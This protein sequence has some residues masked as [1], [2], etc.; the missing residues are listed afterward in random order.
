MADFTASFAV[1]LQ[2]RISGTARDA[3]QSLR[4]L[5]DKIDADTKSLREMRRAMRRLKGGTT[6]STQAFA[7]LRDEIAAKQATI[8]NA[9]SA[10]IEMGGTFG[11]VAKEATKPSAA[12]DA[13]ETSVSGAA[14]SSPLIAKLS[15]TF[16]ELSGSSVGAAASV[17]AFASKVGVTLVSLLKNPVVIALALA[18]AI[19]KVATAAVSAV[20]ALGKYSVAQASAYRADRLRL[21]GLNSLD[22]MRRRRTASVDDLT[23][24]ILGARDATGA[25]QESLTGYAR[26]LARAGLEGDALRQAVE[27]AGMAATV[28]GE[29][30]ARRFIGL[31]R[32]ARLSGRSVQD[33]TARYRDELG[34]AA[35][36][37]MLDPSRQ[38]TRFKEN[39]GQ[40]F[41]GLK[42]DGFLEAL[43]EIG[44]L[45]SQNSASGRALKSVMESI[46]QPLI[47]FAKRALQRAKPAFQT[48]ILN[49]LRMRLGGV[50]L[51]NTY[52]RVRNSLQ[53]FAYKVQDFFSFDGD[54]I[55]DGLI[56]GLENGVQRAMEAAGE[57]AVA[58]GD[59]FKQAL[60]IA[61]PSRVFAG[62]GGDIS[63]GIV[64]GM[65]SGVV[66]AEARRLAFSASSAFETA[67][68]PSLE[69]SAARVD[70][71]A[72]P[73]NRSQT[74]VSIGD[75]YI[76]AG[77]TSD[78]R[79]LADS[80]REQ[81]A[82]AL[83]GVSIEMGAA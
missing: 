78:P 3:A 6:T 42:L 50:R 32:A 20:V 68:M 61:S 14:G 76:Q 67:P 15:N 56:S 5:Q 55:V 52:R 25:S 24:A 41:S 69:M 31:A 73:R 1:E 83:R 80:F 79:S 40:L 71:G 70:G 17:G 46:F 8:A 29:E 74:S 60:G 18:A 48:M 44:D 16:T 64:R 58:V 57:L 10:F 12:I 65:D 21:E 28:Q 27:A 13:I 34:P 49:V 81:L 39:I 37:A 43:A 30:G 26:Q 4:S 75:I 47:D 77:E 11:D 63:D 23:S 66:A 82:A 53:E 19:I 9:Q 45:F 54:S 62:F 22:R 35:R 59:S 51:M 33:L 2:D 38:I 7:K 72:A 36:A